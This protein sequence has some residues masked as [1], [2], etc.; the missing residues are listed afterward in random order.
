MT[1]EQLHHY[2][3]SALPLQGYDLPAE[4]VAEVKQQFVRIHA[5]AALFVDTPL[6]IDVEAPSVFIP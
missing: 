5:L 2:V 3:D 1:E 4:T 6:P